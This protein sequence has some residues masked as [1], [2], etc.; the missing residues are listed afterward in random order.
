[1]IESMPPK[2]QSLFRG[3]WT[4]MDAPPKLNVYVDAVNR[5]V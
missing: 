1:V 3:V 2:R 5:A 4:G